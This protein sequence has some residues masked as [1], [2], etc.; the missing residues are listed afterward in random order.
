MLELVR[1][2]SLPENANYRDSGCDLHPA[3]L[4]CPLPRCR[5]DRRSGVRGLQNEFRDARIRR[6]R[7]Q[8]RSVPQIMAEIG[9]SRRTVYRVLALGKESSAAA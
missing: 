4:T 8:G 3:C 7:R 9:V 1:A 5:Y 2:D 6:L